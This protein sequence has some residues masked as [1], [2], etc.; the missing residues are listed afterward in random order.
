MEAVRT[1]ERTRASL[2]VSL[3]SDDGL[4]R[5][6]E[7]N[8]GIQRDEDGSYAGS[9]GILRDVTERIDRERELA[10]YEAILET[11]PIGMFAV[12]DEGT[13]I[14]CNEAFPE[15]YHFTRDELIGAPFS[16]IVEEG[17]YESA[18]LEDYFDRLRHL[19]SSD[20][21]DDR[22]QYTERIVDLDGN[23]RTYEVT[24]G[25]LPLEDGEF[26]GSVHAFRDVTEERRYRRELER[27]NRRL[28]NFASF[29]SHDLRNP[30]NVAQG[31]LDLIAEES[32]DERVDELAWSLDR[33]EELIG[34]L[35]TL[36]RE[37]KAIGETEPVS[38]AAIA[39]ESWEA[40]DTPGAKLTVEDVTFDAD[41]ERLRS[42]F[43]NLFRNA[44]EHGIEDGA[45]AS[46]SEDPLLTV[47]AGPLES[48]GS[49]SDGA[50]TSTETIGFYVADDGTGLPTDEDG[51]VDQSLFEVGYTT[52]E[53][54]TGFGTGIVEEIVEA[55]DWSIRARE[56][57]AGGALFEIR[58][59]RP[60]RLP[61]PDADSD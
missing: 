45:A 54:G 35:L 8:V 25:L 22:A 34:E 61:G 58:D 52:N 5:V 59:V 49:D 33:M 51:Q 43:E 37:G 28:E 17:Y 32:D 7:A 46:A 27:Q 31:Y 1:G 21:D 18:M 56:S 42:L 57:E 11:A 20:T 55:H 19:L 50:A 15:P 13:L 6:T 9:V 53:S 38:L 30:L 16:R 41:P 60:A 24:M 47:T 48:S 14:W 2:E 4:E 10:R 39:R 26:T 36:A 44:I 12:D 29:V 40:V 3:E 23:D